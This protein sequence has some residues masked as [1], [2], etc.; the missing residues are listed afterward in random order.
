MISEKMDLPA[1]KDYASAMPFPHVVLDGLWDEAMLERV[2]AEV[3]A[4][5]GWAGEKKF[6]GAEGKRWAADWDSLPEHVGSFLHY[7][8]GPRFLKILEELAGEKGLIP[9]PYLH[10][11]GIHSTG[12]GGFLGMHADFNWHED[13]QL[14]RRLN[15]LVYLNRDWQEN[16][17]GDLQL[18]RKNPD[19][20]LALEKTVFPHFNTTVLF[21]TDDHSFHGHPT[22]LNTPE[23]VRRNSIAAYYYVARKPRGTSELKRRVT[24]YRDLEGREIGR[25]GLLARLRRTIDDPEAAIAWLKGRFRR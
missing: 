21:T 25:Q 7:L 16:W 17:G 14:Y 23:G 1:Y 4:F 9:D 2:R 13:M 19:G 5:D 18:A 3:E 11:G 12:R 6:H 22:P 24:D 15:L 8:N 10:G 20:S